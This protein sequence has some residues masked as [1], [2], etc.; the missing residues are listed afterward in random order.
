MGLSIKV[1]HNRKKTIKAPLDKS[2]VVIRCTINRKTFFIDTGVRTGKWH[3]DDEKLKLKP[4]GFEWTKNNKIIQNAV[5]KIDSYYSDCLIANVA[6]T[7]ESV[8]LLFA[9]TESESEEEVLKHTNFMTFLEEDAKTRTDISFSTRKTHLSRIKKFKEFAG[10]DVAFEKLDYNFIEKFEDYLKIK[11]GNSVN[12]IWASH[13]D[14]KSYIGR[15]IKKGYMDRNANPYED[16]KLKKEETDR[17]PLEDK[18]L[19]LLEGYKPKSITEEIILD[20]FLFSC[21]TGLRISDQNLVKKKSF[22]FTDNNECY[23]TFKMK[24]VHITIRNMPL[25]KLFKGKGMVIAKKY[26]KLDNEPGIFPI[27]TGQYTNRVLKEIAESLNIYKKVTSH[28]GRHT[29]GSFLAEKTNDPILIKTL[30]GHSKIETSMIYINMSKAR[31]E[32]KVDQI[33]W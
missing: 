17:E 10:D 8:K 23:L 16:Y 3:W 4:S 15:A 20:K 25:H 2:S 18:E 28:I 9:H 29:F 14:L 7:R 27:R 32:N 22:N 24:K 19:K 21:Y 26:F 5:E 13:K 11:L 1:I 31:I 6:P 33:K 30:M 12:T